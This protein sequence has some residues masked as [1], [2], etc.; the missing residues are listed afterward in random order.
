MRLRSGDTVIIGGLRLTDRTKDQSKT[1][2][3][4]AGRYD[5]EEEQEVWVLLQARARLAPLTY[6]DNAM[7]VVP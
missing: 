1:A 5:Y 4:L 2:A 6:Q 7:E 3:V